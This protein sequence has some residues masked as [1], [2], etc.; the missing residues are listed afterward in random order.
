MIE[1]TD[2][3]FALDSIPAI[4]AITTDPYIV[5]SSNIFAILGLRSMY[6]FLADMMERF[7]YLKQ[8]VFAILIFVALKLLSHEFIHLPEWLSLSVIVLCMAAGVYFSYKKTKKAE[9]V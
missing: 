6:F 7:V 3:L 2:L 1:L 9:E 4:L 5:F 8:S